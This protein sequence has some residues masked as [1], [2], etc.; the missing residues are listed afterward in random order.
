VTDRLVDAAAIA[1]LLSV[2]ESWVREATRAGRLPH[3]ELGRYKRYSIPDVLGW[4][5]KQKTGGAPRVSRKHD[6]AAR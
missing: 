1:E 6:P 3:F 5:E 4:V 2:P